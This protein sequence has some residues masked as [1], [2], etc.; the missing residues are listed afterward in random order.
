MTAEKL[1]AIGADLYAMRD[2]A[3]QIHKRARGGPDA[4]K[5]VLGYTELRV[6]KRGYSFDVLLPGSRIARVSV[7]LD[8]VDPDVTF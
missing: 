2:L 4:M 1:P 6:T 7:E 5:N 3:R 8:R